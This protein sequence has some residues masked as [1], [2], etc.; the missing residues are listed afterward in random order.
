M[1]RNGRAVHQRHGEPLMGSWQSIGSWTDYL[2][3][4]DQEWPQRQNEESSYFSGF[5]ERDDSYA[6]RSH[7][8]GDTGS[9]IYVK[10]IDVMAG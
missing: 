10:T 7:R 5:N 3:S 9:Y 1:I 6:V 8:S 2:A 4:E